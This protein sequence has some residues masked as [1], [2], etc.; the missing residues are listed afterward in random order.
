M[1]IKAYTADLCTYKR[2]RPTTYC[3]IRPATM[4]FIGTLSNQTLLATIHLVSM[5]SLT[6]DSEFSVGEHAAVPV[7]SD[8]LVHPC[9]WQSQTTDGQRTVHH[10]D[11]VLKTLQQHHNNALVTFKFELTQNLVLPFFLLRIEWHLTSPI[12]R[13]GI[14]LH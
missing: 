1:V 12:A 6:N 9:I 4:C 14:L 13:C 10:L 8:T 3:K 7:L 5:K 11:S 2:I